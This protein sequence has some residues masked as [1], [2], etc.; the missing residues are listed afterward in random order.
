MYVS[1][2]GGKVTTESDQEAH[3]SDLADHSLFVQ[4]LLLMA[5]SAADEGLLR[6]SPPSDVVAEIPGPAVA[7]QQAASNSVAKAA[8]TNSGAVVNCSA[9]IAGH[10]RAKNASSLLRP[11]G[12]AGSSQ[13]HSAPSDAAAVLPGAKR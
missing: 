8:T 2:S 12:A 1:S 3:E 5:V 9:K 10:R 4:E 6:A 7:A 13:R 11:A